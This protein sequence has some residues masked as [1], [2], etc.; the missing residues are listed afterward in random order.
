LLDQLA[1]LL[2]QRRFTPA[3]I[4]NYVSWVRRYIFFHHVRHPGAMGIPEV[5]A[6]LDYL[7]GPGEATLFEMAEAGQALRFLYDVMLEK[8]L[9]EWPW[10]QGLPQVQGAT[11]M[12]AAPPRLLEQMRQLL[13]VRRYARRT[14][15]CYVDWAR[16][17]I[18]F[19]N[20][21]HPAALG[22]GEVGRFLTDLAA[23]G[24]VTASTQNQALNALLFLYQQVLEIPLGRL[25]FLKATR[26]GRL[27]V[28]LSR[29]EVKRVLDAVV[30]GDGLF[31]LMVALLYGA[32]LRLLECC[33]LRV[34]DVD[35]PRGQ[36]LVRGGKGDKD[37]VVPL[38]HSLRVEVGRR[39]ET[40]GI[41][42][43]QD[44]AQGV[45][46]VELPNAL[47]RKYPG[48]VRQ[49]G[50]QFLF[51]GR[52]RSRDPRTGNVGRHHVH[53]SLVQR[54]VSQARTRAGVAKRVSPHVF[55]HSF[56]TH[57]LE[58]GHDVRTVQQLLGHKDANTTMIY[59]HVMEKG[60]AGVRSPL[61]LLDGLCPEEVAAAVNATRRL[62]SVVGPA[63][64]PGSLTAARA[65]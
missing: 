14:E 58:Q 45:D 19:H 15:D 42:H 60:V 17:Y 7:A 1:D 36:L 48:A 43:Q 8:S 18:L 6:F 21:Q 55:R 53:E 61:D 40:R 49:L 34:Q 9:G 22:K 10:P 12:P 16:R 52:R 27:P 30:G 46:W 24:Q 44:L 62:G 25:D 20:K 39:V 4:R 28:V 32:G 51:A 38:P 57:L 64:T 11:A 5:A 35:L 3:I 56:A 59:L 47:A 54:A 31:R 65:R 33:R 29:G 23:N 13:R 50:W 63:A 2:Y 41:T 37:R 26:P